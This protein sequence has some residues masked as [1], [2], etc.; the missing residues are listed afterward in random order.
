MVRISENPKLPKGGLENSWFWQVINL[1]TLWIH[2]P[3]IQVLIEKHSKESCNV[4]KDFP[5]S[6]HMFN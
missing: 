2:D 6:Y 5:I 4:W 3:Y 1:T